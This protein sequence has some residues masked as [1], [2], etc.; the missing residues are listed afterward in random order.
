MNL[1]LMTAAAAAAMT[2]AMASGAGATVILQDDFNGPVLSSPGA[3]GNG[4]AAAPGDTASVSGGV[5]H[6][7]GACC[8]KDQNIYSLDTFNPTGTTLTWTVDSKPFIGAAG[9]MIGFDAG[10]SYAC[11]GCGPEIWL[12][13]R[14]DRT[15]FDVVDS[16][17]LWRYSGEGPVGGSGPLTMSLSLS[18]T[19]WA[20][21]LSDTGGFESG[22]GAW[23]YGFA[24][25][26]VMATAGGPLATF[27]SVR[28]DCPGCGDGGSFDKALLERTGS[29]PEP[30]S[31]AL[32][33]SGFGLLGAA[34][35]RRRAVAFVA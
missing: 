12:E 32:M 24:P 6:V 16:S 8:N 27:G 21:S 7:G 1:K 4:F 11:A 9:A 28:S 13:S 29:V 3:V 23:Q 14:N 30:A 25:N 17:G 22:S 33:I 18:T 26:N 31:W 10:G 2:T 19:G 15:V 5:A 20:W 35:R 34:L